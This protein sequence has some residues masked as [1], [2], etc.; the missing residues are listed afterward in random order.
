[1]LGISTPTGCHLSLDRRSMSARAH[2]CNEQLITKAH[3]IVTNASCTTN[4]LAPVV[5]LLSLHPLYDPAVWSLEHGSHASS[6]PP[7][8]LVYSASIF[9]ASRS[10]VLLAPTL[11]FYPY[12]LLF[13]S[14]L[15]LSLLFLSSFSPL[16][17]L[18]LSSFSPLSLLFLSSLSLSLSLLSLSPLSPPSL[19][20][21]S[22]YVLYTSHVIIYPSWFQSILVTTLMAG[23][24]RVA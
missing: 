24:P 9:C 3:A 18:F 12:S 15:C 19:S 16:S 20:P 23:G 14:P 2:R 6:I 17:F 5:L 10:S 4:C 7:E 22:L 11:S 21:L 8:S 13:L 1:M